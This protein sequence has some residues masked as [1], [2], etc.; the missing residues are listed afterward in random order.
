MFF[1]LQTQKVSVWPIKP[2][3]VSWSVFDTG[4]VF[5]IVFV[6][7]LADLPSESKAL[8]IQGCGG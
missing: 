5:L 4:E 2:F 3:E 1:L 6:D 8:T 7:T